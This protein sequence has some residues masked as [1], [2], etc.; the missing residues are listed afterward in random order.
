MVIK[1]VWIWFSL[2][3]KI[4]LYKCNA[5]FILTKHLLSTVTVTL[6]VF[7][8]NS[9]AST[10]FF[11]LLHN[12]M[13][14]R[15]LIIDLSSLSIRFFPFP[16]SVENFLFFSLKEAHS[17]SWDYLN[18]QHHYSCAVGPLLSKMKANWTE[19]LWANTLTVDLIRWQLK[20]FMAQSCLTLCDPTDCS[21]PAS[22][23][24]GILQARILEWVA[25]HS[26]GGLPD[27]GIEP[28][29]SALQADSLL[30]EPPRKLRWWL[31]D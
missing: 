5:F 28:K 23:V 7:R 30:S 6:A 4:S 20:V 8:Y 31:S 26:L 21:P 17:F 22:S 14:R 27:P 12:F 19:A 16:C 10:N 13:D 29:S 15:L 18:C 24:H 3:L 1:V 9:K 2:S 25:S 11:V